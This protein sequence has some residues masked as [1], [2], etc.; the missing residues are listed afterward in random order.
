MKFMFNQ[1]ASCFVCATDSG[2]IVYDVN[3]CRKR[4][5]HSSKIPIDIAQLHYK[6]EWIVLTYTTPD[7]KG[8]S[9][10]TL[11]IWDDRRAT[12]VYALEFAHSITCIAQTHKCVAVGFKD[13]YCI[14]NLD[15][16]ELIEECP[17]NADAPSMLSAAY[18]D[19]IST[20]A[21]PGALIGQVRIVR[22]RHAEILE[23][24]TANAKTLIRKLQISKNTNSIKAHAHHVACIAL[25]SDGDLMATASQH[26]TM[27]RIW[28]VSTRE[29]ASEFRRGSQPT[30][31]RYLRWNN[32]ST[33]LL[34]TSQRGTIHV[35]CAFSESENRKSMLHWASGVLPGYFG[36]TWSRYKI[37]CVSEELKDCIA[38]FVPTPETG[39]IVVCAL[40]SAGKLWRFCIGDGADIK[41]EF[42][43][44]QEEIYNVR[45]CKNA[46]TLCP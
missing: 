6:S 25:S 20:F 34:A 28:R 4:W 45:H 37:E 3:P 32:S 7:G 17:A 38:C 13:K 5:E 10:S 15:N 30:A 36:S 8:G 9:K 33:H 21:M 11:K 22:V 40:T 46:I 35:F 41:H 19:G 12:C 2:F 27:I 1:D 23:Q 26:G 24:C 29:V 39:K 44:L 43:D 16:L 31:I 42:V 18:H 14:Y